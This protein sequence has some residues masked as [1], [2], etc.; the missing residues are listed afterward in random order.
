MSF[1]FLKSGLNTCT[2]LQ[3]EA[4][5]SNQSAG[6]W[7]AEVKDVAQGHLSVSNEG[8]VSDA[9]HFPPKFLPVR[10]IETTVTNYLTCKN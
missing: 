1:F 10:G 4:V 2:Q 5:Q 7:A 8:G 3:L 6:N 9:F